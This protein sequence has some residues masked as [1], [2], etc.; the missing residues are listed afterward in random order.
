MNAFDHAMTQLQS[1]AQT[2]N[3]EENVAAL[4]MHPQKIH[5]VTIPVKNA[6]GV[7][8]TYR[9]YRVQYNNARGPYKGGIRFH[10][11]VDVD[12]VKALSF[13]MAIKCAVVDIPYGGGKGGVEVDPQKLTE[14]ELEQLA[15][16]YVRGLF[17]EIGPYQDI[18]APDVNTMPQIMGWMMDEYSQLVGRT[19]PAA[20]TGKPVAAGGIAERDQAT[21]KGGLILLEHLREKLGKKPQEMRVAVQ[22]FGNVGASFAF[23]AHDAGY[24]IVGLS[25]SVGAIV[26]TGDK[27]IDPYA[28]QE[29]IKKGIVKKVHCYGDVCDHTNYKEVSNAELLT[30]DCDVLVPAALENQITAENARDIQASI[31]IE[32]ANGPTTPEADQI[33]TERDVIIVPDVLANA[34]GVVVSYFEWLQNINHTLHEAGMHDKN[35]TRIMVD[36]YDAVAKRQ[37]KYAVPMRTAA[38]ILAIERIAAAMKDRGWV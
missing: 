8:A 37:Q 22:G 38:F 29:K 10:P 6:D 21:G 25:D 34:G 27:A 33:L 2:L 20:F 13:W 23:L 11:Q 19:E 7:L 26:A 17:A 32:L 4:L 35:L 5:E 18:P 9:G 14:A 1:A 31:I 28:V 30:M 3:L 15:R 16:G 24:R 36:A 12:E